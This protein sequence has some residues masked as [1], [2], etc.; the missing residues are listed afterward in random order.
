[1]DCKETIETSG[2]C[3]VTELGGPFKVH[4]AFQGLE[5]NRNKDNAELGTNAKIPGNLL[6]KSF[7]VT[8]GSVTLPPLRRSYTD[9]GSL[10]TINKRPKSPTPNYTMINKRDPS[11][12]QTPA[13]K[14]LVTT[15][16]PIPHLFDRKASTP[17]RKDGPPNK[18]KQMWKN[19]ITKVVPARPPIAIHSDWKAPPADWDD[20]DQYIYGAHPMF[21][22]NLKYPMHK[23]F[24]VNPE[25]LSEYMTV[26]TYSQAYRTCALRYGWCA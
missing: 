4:S 5:T 13:V 19:E 25:W 1:M 26:S 18:T 17:E 9:I 15:S 11:R 6:R 22:K 8:S 7:D 12:L 20:R 10:R 14:A 23:D 16:R 24:T 21:Y 3:T 2:T